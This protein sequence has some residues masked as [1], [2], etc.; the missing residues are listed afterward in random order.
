MA[1]IIISL[2]RTWD[3]VCDLDNYFLHQQLQKT[4]YFLSEEFWLILMSNSSVIVCSFLHR[5]TI[6]AT[7]V[8]NFIDFD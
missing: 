2:K 1:H 8:T 7:D 3:R 6:P 5:I 4:M